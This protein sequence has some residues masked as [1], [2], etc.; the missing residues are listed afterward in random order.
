MASIKTAR[1]R[2][3][4]TLPCSQQ[5]LQATHSATLHAL[6]F[7]LHAMYS[8]LMMITLREMRGAVASSARLVPNN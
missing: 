4:L 1:K 3:P 2:S 6:I 7:A 5:S 8:R